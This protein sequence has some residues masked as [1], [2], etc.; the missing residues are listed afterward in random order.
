MGE[1]KNPQEIRSTAR[2]GMAASG[3]DL[4]RNHNDVAQRKSTD[5]NGRFSVLLGAERI[6]AAPVLDIRSMDRKS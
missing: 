6:D 1:C 3:G 4:A 2:P 5:Q